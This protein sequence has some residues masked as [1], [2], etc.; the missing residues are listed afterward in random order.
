MKFMGP[1]IDKIRTSNRVPFISSFPA[2][3][4]SRVANAR[5]YTFWQTNVVRKSGIYNGDR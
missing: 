3:I 1:K 2:Q 5:V 4:D